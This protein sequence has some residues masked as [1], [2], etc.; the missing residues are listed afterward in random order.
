MSRPE[1]KQPANL[2]G[3]GVGLTRL[4]GSTDWALDAA[5][6]HWGLERRDF[7]CSDQR[8]A[9]RVGGLDCRRIWR[10]RPFAAE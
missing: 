2:K 10:S 6:K 8:N 7:R 3:K 5:L 9:R 4:G 1:I